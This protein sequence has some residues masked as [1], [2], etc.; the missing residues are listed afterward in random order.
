[1]KFYEERSA[2]F[3]EESVRLS[4]A[5]RRLGWSRLM[6]ALL[7]LGSL[8][9]AVTYSDGAYIAVGGLGVV[10]AGLFRRHRQIRRERR[11]MEKL[12]LI[13][14]REVAHLQGQSGAFPSG[15][16]F[17]PV[18]HPFSF[19]L[20]LLGDK[21]LFQYLCRCGTYSGQRQLAEWLLSPV[22]PEV[23]PEQQAAVKELAPKTDWRQHLHALSLLHEDQ[24]EQHEQL[25]RWS[26]SPVTPFAM[27]LRV[28]S[29]VSPAVMVALLAAAWVTREQVWLNMVSGL[30][31][32]HLL[33]ASAYFK[34]MRKALI[35][36]EHI[37]QVLEQYSYI[38]KKI[39][40]EAFCSPFLQK[41]ASR[42]G[43]GDAAASVQIGRLSILLS[44]LDSM[45][46]LMGVLF[47]TGFGLY[48]LHVWRQLTDWKRSYSL[49]IT[50]WLEVMGA[51]EA[52]NSLANFSA[53]HP[54][55]AF[56]AL[57]SQPVVELTEMGHPLI[58]P[59]KRVNNDVSFARQRFMVLTGSNMS[60]KS[61]FLRAL[62]VNMVLARAGAPVCAGAA[63]VHPMPMWVS[64]RLT[65]S[66]SDSESYFFA[67]IKRLKSI[68]DALK[69]QTTFVLLDE[70]LR[71]TNS[72]DKR[73]GTIAIV[74]QM[75]QLN[76]IGA[77]ATHDLEVCTVTENYP[78]TL[79]NACFEVET[80]NDEL[81][82]D[83]R[84]RQGICRNKSATF[85]MKKTGVIV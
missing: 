30:L 52:L 11:I 77:I 26:R 58:H 45:H 18:Q 42:L 59:D 24:A 25:V 29:W 63:R 67:E 82:F 35:Q 22:S 7:F 85:L 5:D 81:V 80:S 12:M 70:I 66:L 49:Q 76:A 33:V 46:N 36:S 27:W 23:L 16:A 9:A 84:L 20:D 54:G 65:D 41:M 68:I 32:V 56:P 3:K 19:D 62:G 43:K 28:V 38:F 69:E 61:T 8:W 57:E 55:Y 48:H 44:R 6:V 13:N 34:A 2:Y 31:T 50:Q 10:F 51:V 75:A 21:S 40:H 83:Y 79:V 60:G 71:G 37:K 39:E 4:A 15:N 14:E 47:L 53:Q 1:M 74:H 72:D 17:Q 64:M 78:D 73:S